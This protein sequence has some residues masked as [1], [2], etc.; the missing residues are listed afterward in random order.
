MFSLVIDSSFNFLYL[1]LLYDGQV[2]EVSTREGSTDLA[3]HFIGDIHRLLQRKQ[4]KLCQI[5]NLIV[6]IGPG[7]YAGCRLCL[8]VAKVLAYVNHFN[9]YTI[10][11][12]YLLSSGYPEAVAYFDA[13]NGNGFACVHHQGQILLP[14]TFMALEQ[15]FKQYHQPQIQIG[16]HSFQVNWDYVL[17]H[18]TLVNDYELIEPNYLR[19]HHVYQ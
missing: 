1:A 6:G 14:D 3:A 16:L 9:F 12:L 11:S 7:S 18:L 17:S 13:R 2:L 19:E 5:K 15:L 4:L 10:S 8:S